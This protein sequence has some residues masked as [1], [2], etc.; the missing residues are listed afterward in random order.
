M[1]LDP[2]CLPTKRTPA[3]RR[4]LAFARVQHRLKI[5]HDD[6]RKSFRFLFWIQLSSFEIMLPTLDE[7]ETLVEDRLP[8]FQR[9]RKLHLSCQP[10]LALLCFFESDH[11]FSPSWK[12]PWTAMS[13]AGMKLKQSVCFRTKTIHWM[14]CTSSFRTVTTHL[15][16]DMQTTPLG[17]V[18][19]PTDCP[20]RIRFLAIKRFIIRIFGRLDSLS[21]AHHFGLSSSTNLCMPPQIAC[22]SKS[23]LTF[24][25]RIISRHFIEIRDQE[26]VLFVDSNVH[27]GH[28]NFS[29]READIS[30]QTLFRCQPHI[31]QSSAGNDFR[32]KENA[33]CRSVELHACRKSLWQ[34]RK[35]FLCYKR[36]ALLDEPQ[37]I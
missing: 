26:S 27:L 28:P 10:S 30:T 29:K 2:K 7:L 5:K 8:S 32:S 36:G 3:L 34:T 9:S 1:A 37:C 18:F 15:I 20:S 31:R 4:L 12:T 6:M 25:K 16:V 24:G 14:S 17:V 22:L 35:F 13:K 33:L 11:F 19:H 23:C 21:S